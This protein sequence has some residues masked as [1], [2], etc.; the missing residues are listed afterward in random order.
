M[1]ETY[2]AVGDISVLS[3]HEPAGPLGFLPMH[4]YLIKSREPILIETGIYTQAEGFLEALRA[5]I[6]PQELR[7]IMITHEDLDHAGNLEM[8][9]KAAPRARLVLSFLAMLKIARP[10]LITPD[11]I[12]IATPG[13]SFEAGGRRFG[14][15]RPPVFD[16]S[17]T[18]GYFDEKTRT[19]FSADSFGGLVP[20]PTSDVDAIGEGYLAGSTIFMS[21]NTTWL[22]DVDP[23]K[24]RRSVDVVRTLDPDV[25]LPS[26]GAP[27][28]DRAPQLCDHLVSLPASEPFSFPN[29]A[30]FREMLAEMKAQAAAEQP[31]A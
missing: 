12:V 13:E 16:S 2:R 17:G 4:A 3:Y 11:R 26:H 24:F 30:G 10:D 21:A 5:E 20:T 19:L 8:M 28:R 6:D 25:I 15:I 23:A 29:D 1:D 18:V 27:L 22:H 7:W 14:V 31:A 9:M